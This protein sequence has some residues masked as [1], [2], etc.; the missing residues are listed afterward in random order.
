MKHILQQQ[1][2]NNTRKKKKDINN[3]VFYE[4]AEIFQ[5]IGS[6]SAEFTR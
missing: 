5:S 2:L 3:F 1:L 4:S 6:I